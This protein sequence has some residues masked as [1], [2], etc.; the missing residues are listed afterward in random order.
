MARKINGA[1]NDDAKKLAEE[2]LSSV[3]RQVKFTVSEYPVSLYVERFSTDTDDR[4]FVPE[5]QRLLVWND[6][7]KSQFIESLLVPRFS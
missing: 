4:Y 7:Q 6:E 5:Y 3:S 2:A 1:L